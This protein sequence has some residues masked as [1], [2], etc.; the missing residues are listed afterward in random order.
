MRLKLLCCDV[1]FREVCALVAESPHTCD[2]EFLPRGLHD[3]GS[4]RMSA[5]L[6][7]RIDAAQGDSYDAVCLVYGLCNNGVVGLRCAFTRLVVPR[8]HD[9]IAI[10]LGSHSRYQEYFEA[11]PGTWY[12]TTGWYERFDT[13]GAGESSV[14]ERMGLVWERQKLVEKYGEENADYILETMGDATAHY[15][16]LTFIEMGLACEADFE[17]M[18]AQEAKDKGWT[19]EKSEGSMNLLRK[20][21]FGDW[22]D[23]FLILEPG[24][25][26][27]P[28]HDAGILR[29]DGQKECKTTCQSRKLVPPEM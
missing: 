4:E 16:H 21:V 13:S 1:F 23:D 9:C 3:L 6:Q 18:A 12:R 22:D 29:A 25:K 28:T 26:I 11:H 24:E 15:D 2:I 7:E 10:F 20:T 14:Q 5:R 27:V 8:V 17:R 19:F